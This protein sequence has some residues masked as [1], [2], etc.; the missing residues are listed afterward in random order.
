[1]SGDELLELAGFVTVANWGAILGFPPTESNFPYPNPPRSEGKFQP[2][3]H[4][5]ALIEVQAVD[6]GYFEVYSRL[7]EV[8]ALLRQR[9]RVAE[10]EAPV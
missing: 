7:P 2:I 8:Q 10:C 1:M 9:F 4:P 5:R 3:Q 6:G